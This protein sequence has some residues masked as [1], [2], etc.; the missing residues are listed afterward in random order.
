MTRYIR[1]SFLLIAV[2][3]LE[4]CTKVPLTGRRQMN[5]LPES[6][7]LSMSLTNYNDYLK[8]NAPVPIKDQ[9]ARKVKDIG[10][11]ISVAVENFMKEQKQDKRLKDFA[12]E[13]NLVKDDTPNAWCMPGGKVVVN[14]GII[15]IAKD[16]E[17][18]ACIM[19]H[20]IAHAVARHGNERLSQQL[21]ITFG[22]I[23]LEVAMKEKPK[24]TKDLF[25]MAYGAGSTLGSLAY[26]RNHEKEADRLGLIFMAMAGY[27][28]AKAIDF[29]KR[30]EQAGS[31]GV[32]EFLSTHPSHGTRI[33]E[34]EKNLAEANKY[35]KKP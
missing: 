29:W 20:E 26:S 17:G 16:D 19:G 32:P 11:K 5:L 31:S 2:L 14:S 9:Q 23:G 8:Q 7:L 24:E 6:M 18:L 21:L 15:P 28:P 33:S 27:N 1:F 30:M 22:A 10:G 25:M 13:F 3:T 4:S 12:W 35:Y 34:L